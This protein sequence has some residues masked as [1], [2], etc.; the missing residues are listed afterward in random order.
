MTPHHILDPTGEVILVVRNPNPSFA[1]W[2]STDAKDTNASHESSTQ[3]YDSE[4]EA[5]VGCGYNNHRTEASDGDEDDDFAE[6]TTAEVRIQVSAKHLMLGS[7]VFN[8]MLSGDW[9]EGREL[10]EKGSVELVIPDWDIEALLVVLYIM[11]SRLLKVPRQVTLENLAKIAVIADYYHCESVQF[12]RTLWNRWVPKK[13]PTAYTRDV[14][15]GLWVSHFFNWDV[16][17]SAYTKAAT[18]YSEGIIEPLG[19]PIPAQVL[20]GINESR[21]SEIG[22][23]VDNFYELRD[24]LYDDGQ[25]FDGFSSRASEYRST[26]LGSIMRQMKSVKLG[27]VKPD[28]P[29]TGVRLID[30]QGILQ[31]Q[32]PIRSRSYVIP[33]AWDVGE[34]E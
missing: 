4:T 34:S 11:H 29:Y 12:F 3:D 16:H 6:T 9:A 17:F 27:L 7:S 2:T 14:L 22:S 25:D 21:T 10:R 20:D 33:D 8:K 32:L 19:L 15:L 30:V 1:V 28:A 24:E 26:M 18:E 31:Y 5:Y 23:L 13:P